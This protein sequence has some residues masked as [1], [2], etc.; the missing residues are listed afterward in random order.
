MSGERLVSVWRQQ[1]DLLIPRMEALLMAE[2]EK[3]E[4]P[5]SG[6]SKGRS[7]GEELLMALER[8]EAGDL[9][10]HR[11]RP[12]QSETG[13]R[14]H[15]R[16]PRPGLEKGGQLFDILRRCLEIGKCILLK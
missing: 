6:Y 16:R 14:L 8:E 11:R 15:H 2:L 13:T 9:A 3:L 5:P 1:E 4:E 7:H 12:R 10:D